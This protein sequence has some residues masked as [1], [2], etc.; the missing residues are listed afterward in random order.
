MLL[1]TIQHQVQ[2]K[3][4]LLAAR[5]SSELEDVLRKSLAGQAIRDPGAERLLDGLLTPRIS[6]NTRRSPTISAFPCQGRA[7]PRVDTASA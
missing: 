6:Q 3:V 2:T 4:V 5:L 7:S 1:V